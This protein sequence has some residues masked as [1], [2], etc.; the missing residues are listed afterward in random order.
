MFENLNPNIPITAA[1]VF[2]IVWSYRQGTW[3][4]F[5]EALAGTKIISG[6]RVAKT[7]T[8]S[9]KPKKSSPTKTPPEPKSVKF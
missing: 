8:S 9:P 7:T 2:Y 1:F 6:T 4:L 3:P 5:F